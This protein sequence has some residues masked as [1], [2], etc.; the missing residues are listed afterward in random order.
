M[1]FTDGVVVG[2]GTA[3]VD[4]T[5]ARAGVDTLGV[6]T[7]L[8]LGTVVA[9]ETLR[10]ALHCGVSLVV[11][12]T[13]THRL[14]TLDSAV[15]VDTTGVGIAGISG[16]GRYRSQGLHHTAR[17]GASY[18]SRGTTTDGVVLSDL[19]HSTHSTGAWAGVDTLLGDT[20][21]PGAAV[22]VLETL[23]LAA[24]AG[25]G[26]PL[27][28]GSAGAENLASSVLTAV[29]V[30]AAG[31]GLAGVGWDAALEWV[32]SE[33]GITPAVLS[34]IANQALGVVSTGPGLAQRH[35][36]GLWLDWH[37]ALDGV[38][39]L[40]V[41][42]LA[43]A[44][45][46]VVHHHTLSVGSTRVGLAGLDWADTRDGWR[47][48]FISRQTETHRAVRDHP[49]AGVG[50]ALVSATLGAVVDTADEGVAGLTP[51]TGT[52][53]VAIVQLTHGVDTTGRGVAGVGQHWGGGAANISISLEAGLAGTDRVVVG[54]T[55]D[56]VVSTETRAHQDT[57]PLESVAVLVLRT[58]RVQSTF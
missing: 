45:L 46:D 44:P 53:G 34:D 32:A 6:D 20:G 29:R 56:G 43:G 42:W 4:T 49:A 14:A 13:L 51:G 48:S 28:A 2:H 22:R 30:G 40:C 39:G 57:F 3:G 50:P 37:T 26:V 19:A 52:D 1:T 35:H 5:G 7:G 58:V 9:Q 47:V 10:F 41:S 8:V 11:S 31:R 23:S 21:Q 12:D 54:R 27:V 17:E 25:D 15:S 18:C 55:A 16:D 24:L 38:D 33:P 36:H